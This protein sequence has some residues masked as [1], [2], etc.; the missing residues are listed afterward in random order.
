MKKN[1]YWLWLFFITA[2]G[3]I[4]AQ[5]TLIIKH[6]IPMEITNRDGVKLNYEKLINAALAEELPQVASH[7]RKAQTIDIIGNV[8]GLPGA[9]LFGYGFGSFLSGASSSGG[10]ILLVGTALM[11]VEL[12]INLR[13]RNRYIQQGIKEYN[14]YVYKRRV[15]EQY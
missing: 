13:F 6:P 1:I 14:E 3:Q 15:T 11:T 7:F 12:G 5:D 2:I 9:F 4:K 10:K 8:I